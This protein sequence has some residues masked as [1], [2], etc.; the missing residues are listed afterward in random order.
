[1]VNSARFCLLRTESGDEKRLYFVT[2]KL[3]A[4][5]ADTIEKKEKR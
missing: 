3:R 1:M 2:F 4:Y 5:F